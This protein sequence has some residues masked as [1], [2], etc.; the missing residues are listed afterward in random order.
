MTSL[1]INYQT[2][3][4]SLSEVP[5]LRKVVIDNTANL[6]DLKRAI[7][8][9]ISLDFTPDISQKYFL[10]GSSTE[11]KLSM[12]LDTD[13]EIEMTVPPCQNLDALI[14]LIVSKK[15]SNGVESIES[16]KSTAVAP[17]K[18]E[19]H[20]LI[21]GGRHFKPSDK[22]LSIRDILIAQAASIS[23][24]KPNGSPLEV[25][26]PG[27]LSI[28]GLSTWHVTLIGK[29][30]EVEDRILSNS[31]EGVIELDNWLIP[32]SIS[33]E[34]TVGDL[35][36]RILRDILTIHSNKSSS[37]SSNG[38]V[39]PNLELE[40]DGH[41]LQDDLQSLRTSGVKC[42][43]IITVSSKDI[44]EE[45][46]NSPD[47]KNVAVCKD[48]VNLFVKY[49][50][51]DTVLKFKHAV[52]RVTSIPVVDQALSLYKQE[53]S[54]GISNDALRMSQCG[55]HAG[56]LIVILDKSKIKSGGLLLESEKI[57]RE[58]LSISFATHAAH[59]TAESDMLPL[60][61]W[62]IGNNSLVYV[63]V[64]HSESLYPSLSSRYTSSS[65]RFKISPSWESWDITTGATSKSVDG[66]HS[67]SVLNLDSTRKEGMSTFLSCL[68]CFTKYL[69]TNKV[70]L[71][72]IL[73]LLRILLIDFPP[74]VLSF[75]YLCMGL[76]VADS[77]KASISQACF[78]LMREML[79]KNIPKNKVFEHTRIFF[80]FLLTQKY[81]SMNIALN[82]SIGMDLGENVEV[83][84][85]ENRKHISLDMGRENYRHIN[86]ICHSTNAIL[87]DPVTVSTGVDGKNLVCSRSAT[88]LL[89]GQ[90]LITDEFTRLLLLCHPMKSECEVWAPSLL[91]GG[92]ST[93]RPSL[94]Y[95]WRSLCL[96]KSA[97]GMMVVYSALS[98][99]K[100]VPPCL[101]I[102]KDGRCVVFTGLGCGDLNLFSPLNGE[103]VE[104]AQIL[105]QDIETL[106]N[107]SSASAESLKVLEGLSDSV[108]SYSP[109]EAVV[110]CLDVSSSMGGA[111]AF[112][113]EVS[114]R[115]LDE[116][117]LK[118]VDHDTDQH[119]KWEKE[120]TWDNSQKI[121]SDDDDDDEEGGDDDDDESD[122]EG[123]KDEYSDLPSLESSSSTAMERRIL[124]E[125]K[126]FDA[127]VNMMLTSSSFSVMQVLAKEHGP[128]LVLREFCRMENY[129]NPRETTS[130]RT[131]SRHFSR[132]CML[133]A[134]ECEAVAPVG[135]EIVPR[136]F[137]CPITAEL[138]KVFINVHVYVLCMY[139]YID[140][141]IYVI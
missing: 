36:L 54:R 98:L 37:S 18:P 13:D 28:D 111:V 33:F 56:S 75:R 41:V 134:G 91:D 120:R 64:Y 126:R 55:L 39:K 89:Q 107:S 109:E 53:N 124:N 82:S 101:T 62:N 46:G 88:D 133:L 131:I 106:K 118:I 40:S 11:Q 119:W 43:S 32:G 108:E 140:V 22:S 76:D 68:F 103:S 125:K 72:R 24:H 129:N 130:Y 117:G 96:R 47:S 6:L 10:G 16:E 14:Y 2:L 34:E 69:S 135:E 29:G 102:D 92:C 57:R 139:T 78:C 80:T 27:F 66:S 49:M 44:E 60:S 97:D 105:A 132:F 116:N 51:E 21:L 99:K 73:A 31:E 1:T 61:T 25:Y 50:P 128:D 84:E 81:D 141:N 4:N 74:I 8:K 87:V 86:L 127:I 104:N 23:I 85:E 136:D 3:H 59:S 63:T 58:V 17:I 67:S 112:P 95:N 79:P 38:G 15:S 110:I 42:M 113:G 77:E 5:L 45:V 123:L 71:V 90:T 115:D 94:A 52:A 70:V 122:S 83:G 12:I 7:A 100:K 35:K 19:V 20:Y 138:L 121:G 48:G 30:E 65:D 137:L 26:G 9:D 114:S 93:N